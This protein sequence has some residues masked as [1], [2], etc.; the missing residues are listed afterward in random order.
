MDWARDVDLYGDYAP[1]A[2]GVPVYKAGAGYSGP[3]TVVGCFLGSDWHWR[4]VVEHK[5]EG[6][7]GHFYHIY[8][9][10]Q[11]RRDDD[12]EHGDVG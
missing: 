1:F 7:Q 2:R 3:G 6:G 8:G 12:R 5:I 9:K 4:V 10:S 11:L